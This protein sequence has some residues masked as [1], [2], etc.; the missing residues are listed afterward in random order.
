MMSMTRVLMMSPL[1]LKRT[2]WPAGANVQLS[3]VLQFKSGEAAP[4]Q[5]DCETP[6]GVVARIAKTVAR[7]GDFM[8]DRRVGLM[9][10]MVFIVSIC[11]DVFMGCGG[12]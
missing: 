1:L 6:S 8:A 4:V 9:T 3:N 7:R 12:F 11:L 5:V 2:F 10:Y